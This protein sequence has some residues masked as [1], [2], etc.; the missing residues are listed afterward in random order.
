MF[1]KHLHHHNALVAT[2]SVRIELTY[3]KL[4]VCS[5]TLRATWIKGN[6]KFPTGTEGLEPPVDALEERGIIHYATCPSDRF[7]SPPVLN[8][9]K[10]TAAV[11]RSVPL[12][13][14]I[15]VSRPS[16]VN[17]PFAK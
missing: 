2:P 11:L 16:F 15:I 13:L 8:L 1:T 5:R 4:T 10:G 7:L 6:I 14:Y 9:S 12:N 17:P 3:N